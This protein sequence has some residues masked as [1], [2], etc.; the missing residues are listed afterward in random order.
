[1]RHKT[2]PFRPLPYAFFGF[3]FLSFLLIP[4][5]GYLYAQQ[6]N[7]GQTPAE[8]FQALTPEQRQAL[9]R[10]TPEQK[11]ALQAEVMKSGGK[12]TP[13]MI[14][15]LKARLQGPQQTPQTQE[16]ITPPP[17]ALSP[18]E[19]REFK[20]AAEKGEKQFE[21]KIDKDFGDRKGKTILEPQRFGLELFAP[22]R[23]R[24]LFL[25]EAISRGQAP[26][27]LQKDALSGFAGPLDMVFSSVNASAPPQYVLNPG[28]RI[29]VY[30]WGDLIE[31]T[32]LN[33]MLDEK[34]EVSVPKAGRFVARGMSLSQL[35][36]AVQDQ[37]SR[38]LG[39]D[40][41]LIASLDKLNSIQIFITGEAFRPG[42][43][44][45][46]AVTTLFNALF[47]AGGPNEQGSLR[48][49]K[50]VRKSA[51]MSV[52]FYDY[53]LNGDGR[54]DLPLQAGDTVFIGRA[55]KLASIAGEVVRPAIFELKKDETLKD[56]VRMAGG[57]KPSGLNNR[58][59]VRSVVPH[60]ERAVVDVDLSGKSPVMDYALYD[61][62]A[63]TVGAIVGEVMNYVT[64][65]GNVKVPGVY[66]LKKNM[67]VADLFNEVNEPW[68]E[69]YLERA[70][71]FRLGK[72]R[73]TTTIISFHLGK[74]L[75]KD[76]GHNLELALW[77]RIVVYSKWDVKYYP[78][79]TVTISGAVQKPGDY[80][81][82]VGMRLKDLL[83]LAGGV[84]P[85]TSNDIVIA[86]ARSFEEVRTVTVKLDLLE[87]GDESQ[88][89]PLEDMDI[90]MVREYSE[91]FERPRWVKISGE[92]KF[93]GTYPLLRKDYRLSELIERAGGLTRMANP[94]GAVFLR[95]R[96]LLPSPEQKG[97]LLAV[98][99]IVNALND[100]DA[101]RQEAR[102]LFLLQ[103]EMGVEMT[104]KGPAVGTGPG[105]TVVASGTSTKE[106]AALALGPSIAQA[107]STLTG[108]IVSAFTAGGAITSSAR[109][110][111][112]EQ[113]AQSERIIINIE[114]GMK[115]GVDNFDDT[116][117]LTGDSIAIPQMTE[118]ASVVGAVMNPV[119]V[120]L[121]NHR[122]VKNLIALAGGYATDADEERAL[123]LRVDG[124]IL[125]AD[126]IGSV[127]E[128]DVL[129]VPTRVVATE[130]I[131]TTD[132]II[133]V[134]K[135]TLATAAGVIVFLA[136]IP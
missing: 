81:R 72:D 92:V 31:L 54:S 73:K 65:A 134:I 14:E 130:I 29:T 66:E 103:Q 20:A 123:V 4:S 117:L 63:V 75:Q 109:A 67:R 112:G 21:E 93:P 135:Y 3:L 107:G 108:G 74:A 98:N 82:S 78:E 49:I 18:Q 30:Y 104:G 76:P 9:E 10:L 125:P 61:G 122:K 131:T 118:T 44:A 84:L 101:R 87:K 120:H 85:G 51:V 24:V 88:N 119:T 59:Q 38:V 70:D 5:D 129:Y 55:G 52:D 26:P 57:V 126:D 37:L 90:V 42:S 17:A 133:N 41:K 68:G 124:S 34:G 106:A 53:L 32:T 36:K 95:K 111:A 100:I 35:Q 116:A 13:E 25:E 23:K 45:V 27:A 6:L 11:Q 28:D 136:L 60:K 110:L 115:G 50:L 46:S 2:G 86:K 89:V 77:D 114:R 69:A 102:N 64:L 1:M 83:D 132:K 79:M 19:T 33:M 39:K 71:I 80:V 48:D 91:F 62:D 40:I 97:D 43:Y 58:I 127:E 113:L 99:R 16:Q 15:Q 96:E 121:G 56:L 105:T 22:S 7:A 94:K 128:G 8:L 12:V 47:A